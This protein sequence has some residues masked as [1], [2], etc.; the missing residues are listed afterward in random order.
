MSS[1]I[2]GMATYTARR[3]KQRWKVTRDGKTYYAKA[4][5]KKWKVNRKTGPLPPVREFQK[6]LVTRKDGGDW[7]IKLMELDGTVIRSRTYN[8]HD[9]AA[10]KAAE[11]V[12]SGRK[13]GKSIHI[14]LPQHIAEQLGVAD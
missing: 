7:N 12:K 9:K 6:I 3:K 2:N 11:W 14:K 1:T 4:R 13:E 5:K 10:E 8:S